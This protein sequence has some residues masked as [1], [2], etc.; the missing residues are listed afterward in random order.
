ME[1]A[2]TVIFAFDRP[3]NLSNVLEGLKDCKNSKDSPLYVFCDGPKN[4]SSLEQKKRIT[5]VRRLVNSISWHSNTNVIYRDVNFGLAKSIISGINEVLE[6]HDKV[7]ILEDDIVPSSGFLEYCNEALELYKDDHRVMQIAG[8]VYDGDFSL[9]E[10]NTFFARCLQCHGW[11]TWKRAW[12]F[13]ND[14]ALDHLTYFDS[15]SNRRSQ[16]DLNSNA[17]FLKQLRQNVSGEINTWAVKWYASILRNDGLILFPK[18]SLITNIGFD[19]NLATNT[20]RASNF[21]SPPW[22]KINLKKLPV[23]I[24]DKAQEGLKTFWNIYRNQ[25]IN[26]A[27]RNILRKKIHRIFQKVFRKLII[28]LVPELKQLLNSKEYSWRNVIGSKKGS[29]VSEK[30]VLY[31]PYNIK[32]SIIGDFTYVAQ[33]SQISYTEIGKYCSIGP[34]FKCGWGIHPIDGLSTSPSFY[35]ANP[36]NEFSLLQ[37]D[38]VVERKKITIGNDVFIGRDVTVLDG[39]SIGDGA[40]IGAGTIVYKDVPEYSVVSSNTMKEI[41][42]RNKYTAELNKQTNKWWNLPEKELVDLAQRLR[43]DE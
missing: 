25:K 7:I 4:S 24:N 1:P 39:V 29:N 20:K 43:D 14:D 37:D 9:I 41:R 17:Y 16:F 31:A 38:M 15:N 8:S 23:Q 40:V 6:R 2:P 26:Q 19:D 30:A 13:F 27:S 21:L 3:E 34:E 10:E 28:S 12:Q 11:A 42:H 32:N 5:E 22:G 33:C 18:A 35:S 36:A